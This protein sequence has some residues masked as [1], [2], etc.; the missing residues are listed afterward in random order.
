MKKVRGSLADLLLK[1]G[2]KKPESMS[3]EDLLYLLETE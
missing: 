3:L 1:S 2:D